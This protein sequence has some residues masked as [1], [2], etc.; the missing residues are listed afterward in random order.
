MTKD[1]TTV[2]L[3]IWAELKDTLPED[4]TVAERRIVKHLAKALPDYALEEE[5][6]DV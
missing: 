4:R 2:L 1:G 5:K 6:L 3:K